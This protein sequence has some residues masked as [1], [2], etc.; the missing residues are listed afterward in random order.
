MNLVTPLLRRCLQYSQRIVSSLGRTLQMTSTYS[1]LQVEKLLLIITLILWYTLFWLDTVSAPQK[2]KALYCNLQQFIITQD[3]IMPLI[4]IVS[5]PILCCWGLVYIRL[6][7]F[8]ITQR[9]FMV[10]LLCLQVIYRERKSGEFR[11]IL[12]CD[13]VRVCAHMIQLLIN[14]SNMID[15]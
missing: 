14:I 2:M 13:S 6:T 7:T 5:P 9:G 12:T 4:M 11:H 15:G 8:V 3:S 10:A 1:V